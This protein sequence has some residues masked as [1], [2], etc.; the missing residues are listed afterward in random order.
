MPNIYIKLKAQIGA[1]DVECIVNRR[2][3]VNYATKYSSLPALAKNKTGRQT[4]D[5][6][7]NKQPISST[8]TQ[9][10]TRYSMQAQIGAKDCECIVIP[11]IRVNYAK[12]Y[13]SLPE[14]S[15]RST[16]PGANMAT[17][18]SMPK[19]PLQAQIGAKDVE[20][21]VMRCVRVNYATKSSSLPDL[22]RTKLTETEI[23]ATKLMRG[24]TRAWQ[25]SKLKAQIGAKD[26]E[27]IVIR[28]VR[29]NYAKKYSSLPALVHTQRTCK[30]QRSTPP[31]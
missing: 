17:H 19:S 25:T 4:F 10:H 15:Q 3:R 7:N 14:H 16:P 22:A 2:V 11:C 18:N 13:S 30:R 12:K 28:C 26:V 5:A 29:V 21:I 31:S 9:E 27:C 24:D 6:T 1:K 23:N 8:T 20:C